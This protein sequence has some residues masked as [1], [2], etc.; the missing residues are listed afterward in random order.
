MV[1]ES[2]FA[3]YLPDSPP[4]AAVHGCS[5]TTFHTRKA[6]KPIR[7]PKDAYAILR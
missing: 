7:K 6:E 3:A 1:H 2:V 4:M 5:N